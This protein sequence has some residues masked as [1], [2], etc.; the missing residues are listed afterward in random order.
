MQDWS[1]LKKWNDNWDAINLEINSGGQATAKLVT[2]KETQ[3]IAFCKILNRQNDIERRA[4][5]F[6]EATAYATANHKLIPKLLESNAHHYNDLTYKIYLLTEFIEGP[7]ITEYIDTNGSLTFDDASVI[8]LGLIDAVEYCHSNEWVHRDIKPDNIILKNSNLSEPILLD[9]G[10]GYKKDVIDFETDYGQE[11]GN[12]FL[13]LPEMSA[14]ST[15]KQDI[16]TDISFLGGIFFYL[17]TTIPPSV[18]MDEEGKMP[19]Q[20]IMIVNKLKSIYQGNFTA[21]LDFFDKSFSQ[22]FS[23]RFT[24]AREMKKSLEGLINMHKNFDVDKDGLSIENIISLLN[25]QV[26]Q[27]L[28]K[29]KHLYDLAMERIRVVHGKILRRVA[30]QYQSYQTGYV[31]FI[32]GLR[33][34]LGFSHFATHDL[35]FVP[36]FLIKVM[37]DELVIMVDGSSIYRT[38]IDSPVFSE[39]FEKIVE[40][41]YL[42]GLKILIEKSSVK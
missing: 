39:E 13:R 8:L 38:E 26:D 1:D 10:I 33:N 42:N 15:S 18:L 37:G 41:I 3:R 4:R 22:K 31:N 12:R 27:E 24:T 17:M 23:S 32:D 5:F 19:H 20:R 6:R 29:N 9:F 30:P 21:L 11:L 36:S 2:N 7:T 14:G 28:M 35:K 25:S 40:K 34:E 16:R